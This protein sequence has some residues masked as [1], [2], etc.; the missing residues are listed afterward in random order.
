MGNWQQNEF[1]E[2]QQQVQAQPVLLSTVA[3]VIEEYFQ[4]PVKMNHSQKADDLRKMMELNAKKFEIAKK[5][6]DAVVIKK[7]DELADEL[8]RLEAE[9]VKPEEKAEVVAPEG[10]EIRTINNNQFLV[11]TV[12]ANDS[13]SHLSLKYNIPARAIKTTNELVS[14]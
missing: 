12:L 8:K 9:E 3:N 6:I 4:K 14:D 1:K 2:V 13:I 7:T 10:S 5:N 11:H